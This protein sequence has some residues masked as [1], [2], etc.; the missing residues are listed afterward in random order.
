MEFKVLN[1]VLYSAKITPDYSVLSSQQQWLVRMKLSTRASWME[2][3]IIIIG[4]LK[5]S[6]QIQS[7]S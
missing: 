3:F 2:H 7:L 5:D 6:L 4:H 1:T